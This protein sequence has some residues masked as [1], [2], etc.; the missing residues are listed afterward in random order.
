LE[1]TLEEHRTTFRKAH[2]NTPKHNKK[3]YKKCYQGKAHGSKHI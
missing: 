1:G 2:P 3:C